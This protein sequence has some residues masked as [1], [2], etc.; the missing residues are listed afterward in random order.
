[1][2]TTIHEHQQVML[3]MLEEVDQICKK[4]GISYQLFAGTALGAVRHKGFIPWDDDL[5]VVMYRPDYERFLQVA[6]PEL[7]TGK[8]YLQKEYSEHWPMFYSKIRR[9]GTAC[10]ERFIPKDEQMHQGVFIDI[11]PC[12]NLSDHLVYR[13]IQFIASKIVIAKS[14][15]MRGYLTDSISKKMFILLCGALPMKPFVRLVQYRN[16]NR[17]K[18]LHTFF[19]GSSKYSRSVFPREWLIDATNVQFESKEYPVSA[20]YPQ[21]LMSLYGDYSIPTPPEKRGCKVH[22]EIVDLEHSYKD[23]IGVQKTMTF[24]EYTHSIR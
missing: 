9:N 20:H 8:Y 24:H 1:M 2:K 18:M 19:G 13:R 5:D 12:D 22:A 16:G 15:G 21:L 14:L 6:A 10:I 17:T 11:F 23:Y 3:E 7:D 4:N